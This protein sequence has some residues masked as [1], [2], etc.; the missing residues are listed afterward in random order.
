MGIQVIAQFV[1]QE[2]NWTK[3]SFIVDRTKNMNPSYLYQL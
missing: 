2:K 1:F 3:T